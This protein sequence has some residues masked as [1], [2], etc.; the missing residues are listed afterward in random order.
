M[1]TRIQ[2]RRNY[3][4]Q[5]N[6][7]N[8]KRMFR[9]NKAKYR[10]LMMM[11]AKPRIPLGL[12]DKIAT[13]LRYAE[14]FTLN[15]DNTGV[16]AVAEY[17]ANSLYDPTSAV[18]GHQYNGYDQ[19]NAFFHRAQVLSCKAKMFPILDSTTNGIASVF[20]IACCNES[21]AL[22]GNTIQD[23]YEIER[24]TRRYKVGGIVNAICAQ[25]YQCREAKSSYSQKKM[26]GKGSLDSEFSHTDASDPGSLWYFICWACSSKSGGEDPASQRFIIELEAIVIFTEPRNLA[27]S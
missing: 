11:S 9:T 18:G 16:C 12:P 1:S 6:V 13:R 14:E 20:G 2:R 24:N 4:R 25:P 15:P 26:F 7:R 8:Y 23:M 3:F 21:G 10:A 19:L 5:R 22:T 17:K 27:G